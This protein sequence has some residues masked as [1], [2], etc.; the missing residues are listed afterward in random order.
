[1]YL[2]QKPMTSTSPARVVSGRALAHRT[3]SPRQRAAIAASVIAG[4]MFLDLSVR[5]VAAVMGTSSTYMGVA[6]KLTPETRAAV[7]AGKYA[8]PFTGH[9]KSSSEAL[10]LPKPTVSDLQLADI[11][12]GAG[13]DRMLEVACLIENVA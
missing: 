10:A 3:M 5:Q 1:M 2:G 8:V 7:A 6:A 11:I 12:R 9:L 13:V 4:E